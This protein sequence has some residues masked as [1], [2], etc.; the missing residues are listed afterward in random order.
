VFY[1]SMGHRD[2]V[3]SNPVFQSILLGGIAW[4]VGDAKAEVRPNIE[5]V[6]PQAWVIPPKPQPKQ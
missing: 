1:T 5:K 4:A 6:T 3:W 2:D